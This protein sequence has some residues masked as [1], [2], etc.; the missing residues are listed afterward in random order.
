[1]KMR[2][3][4]SIAGENVM[5]E[6]QNVNSTLVVMPTGLGKT[7]LFADIVRRFFPRRALVLA[8]REELI[9]QA[10]DKIERVTG[11]TC[12]VEMADYR[13]NDHDMFHGAASVV[14]SSIQTQCSGGDGGGRM[15]K[16]DPAG[17]GLIVVD[18][19][20]PANTLIDGIQIQ[21][22]K[23]GD[24]VQ[25]FNHS[26]N[27]IEIS[28]VTKTFKSNPSSLCQIK[29]SNGESIICTPG[30]PFWSEIIGCYVPA[31]ALEKNSI[32]K[33]ITR[34]ENYVQQNM[35]D[36]HNEFSIPVEQVN[37][38]AGM[39]EKSES[40]RKV[41]AGNIK[42]YDLRKRC[43]MRRKI[44]QRKNT[45]GPSL[46]L[47]YLQ[48]QIR[49]S[50]VVGANGKNQSK[51]CQRKNETKQSNEKIRIARK[52]V[53]DSKSNELE[54]D[55]KTRKWIFNRTSKNACNCIKLEYGTCNSYE[56]EKRKRLS[57]LLQNR[58]RKCRIKNCHRNRRAKSF[59]IREEST[60]QKENR[61]TG[62]IG[63]E[64]VEILKSTSNKQFGKLC[65]DGYV[66]NIEVENH[67]N[68]FANGILVHNC[69]HATS[70]SYRRII[71]YYRS[72]PNVKILGVTATPDRAD[73]EALGQIYKTV[74]FDYEILDAINDGW[75]VPIQQQI[76]SVGALDFSQVRTTA[77]DLNGGDLAEIMEAEE[78]LHSIATP[79]MEIIGNRRTLVFASSVKHAE[80]LAEIFNR[81]KEGC[82]AWVCGKT[83]KDDRRK[84][85]ADFAAGRIQIVVNCAVL[86]EGFDDSGV[87]VIVMG[88][89]TKSRSLYCQ[90]VG[91]ATRPLPGTVDG[92]ETA[93]LRKLS[94][95][96]S[97]KPSCLII[98]FV[99]NSGRHKLMTSADILGGKCSD[100]ALKKAVDKITKSKKAMSMTD[101]LAESE[102]EI[103]SEKRKKELLES[104]KRIRLKA[105]ASFRTQNVNP[106]DVFQLSP[107]KERGWDSNKH[108][109]NKQC[110][111]LAKNGIAD[112]DKMPY[113]QAKQ[114]LNEMFRR[115]DGNLCSFKQA[116]ILAKNGLPVD[117][118][119]EVATK[120]IDA[121][122]ANGWKVPAN[123]NDVINQKESDH[124][125]F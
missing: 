15:T 121:I 89:P 66:Y 100:E 123:I 111:L 81:H 65:P 1:M 115:W 4:Q 38:L 28:K 112:A 82:A 76:V 57:V 107:V 52:Y 69:H 46:L 18:E 36:M 17:F 22:I 47:N 83:P 12:A 49:F 51:I 74:A 105:A 117:V 106:F 11:L 104:A 60:G 19:C 37:M 84:I 95:E 34:R 108:L 41:S 116:K 35:Q 53:S 75:L 10:K 63:V 44:G 7:I 99:G 27:Q 3:Y 21:D 103:K 71:E 109:S 92:P 6:F 87:E 80:R 110:E 26:T 85:L 79:T 30:H 48:G 96:N 54:T 2:S 124:V 39:R 55:S 93:E 24:F 31:I 102:E 97:A 32:L 114:L 119:R 125:P 43:N 73:E 91:R 8:H 120:A 25:C 78:C 62:I 59:D 72:N 94:I 5:A 98:D 61:T 118:S 86:T 101:A 9:F 29:L 45:Q 90:C 113:G 67:H 42:V 16:F 68:Y 23:T 14:V 56:N 33:T 64:S 58:H 20:F 122:V 88:K 70:S 77:G 13:V 50:A 40:M